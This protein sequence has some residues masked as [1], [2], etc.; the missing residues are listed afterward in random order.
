MKQRQGE[1]GQRADDLFE[2]EK[3]ATVAPAPFIKILNKKKPEP[4]K[5]DN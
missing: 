3:D 1:D 2:D 5:K 4:K